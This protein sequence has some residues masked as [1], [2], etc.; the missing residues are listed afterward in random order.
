MF[1]KSSKRT[2]ITCNTKKINKD[3][4]PLWSKKDGLYSKL[5]RLLNCEDKYNPHK[6]KLEETKP[7]IIGTELLAEL[8]I[9]EKNRWVFYWAA[10]AGSSV[11]GD[12]VD[13]PV[14]SYGDESNHGLIK[15]DKN[16]DT[17]LTLNCP[18]LY[19]VDETLYPRHIHYSV[20]TDE[21]VWST[22][23]GT[24]EVMCNVSNELLKKIQKKKT[25]VLM[26]ALSKESYDANHI[27]NS[28]LCHHESL[29]GLNK[30]KKTGTI[31]QLLMENLS[32]YPPIKKFINKDNIKEIPIIVYCANKDCPASL[33][34]AEHLYSC[35]FY[36]VIEYKGGINE[37]LEKSNKS[38]LFEDA[39][40]DDE[41]ETS[42]SIHVD[43]DE[44][45]DDEEIIV[46]DG[47]EYIHKL[48]DSDEIL[49]KEDNT[50][51]GN[52]KG[53][54]IIW[55][56]KTEYENHIK[57]KSE[58]GNLLISETSSDSE[59]SD[60]ENSDSD[61]D[62]DS[63]NS[64][65][66]N[67]DSDSKNTKNSGSENEE[68][69]DL[70][71]GSESSDEDEDSEDDIDK[72]LNEDYLNSKNVSELRDLLDKMK[73]KVLNK[74]GTK[75]EMI[76]CLLGCKNVYKGGGYDDT[77]MYGGNVTQNVY[78]NHFRGWGFTFM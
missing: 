41:G 44:L 35:G 42:L 71:E 10:E 70:G 56:N 23:I 12:K 69:D 25:Y 78:N 58:K 21:D 20:L 38:K 55:I 22:E 46:Y 27:P 32:L 39:D 11:D 2:C 28:I 72:E 19:K 24:L 37:W 9:E 6:S 60:S 53:E 14:D 15:T 63:E 16:G 50:V 33:K 13:G 77:I 43:K 36:N 73:E 76:K 67:S 29:D 61:S 30:Q 17:I 7:E 64:D 26:N 40:T 49:T 47:V 8:H 65:S 4:T 51:V 31:K 62:S 54:H 75:N 1:K 66:E 52:Y 74:S 57:R 18:K 5:P 59:N 34:L 68:E 45:N 3:N 48:D